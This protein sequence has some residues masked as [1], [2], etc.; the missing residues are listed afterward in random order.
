MLEKCLRDQW[1][2]DDLDWSLVPRPM[3]E[4]EETAIVQYFT[5]MA[6]IELLAG[7]LFEEQAKRAQDPVLRRILQTFVI[8]EAR[9]SQVAARLARHYDVHR[10][11]AY[12]MNPSLVAF[13]PH[14]V[15]AVRYL[16][17]EVATYYI[18]GGELILDVALLR[19]LNDFV[20]DAMSEAAMERINRDESRHIALDFHMTEMYALAAGRGEQLLPKRNLAQR[21]EAMRAFALVLY[22]SKPFFGEVFFGPMKMVDPSGTRLREA[23]KRVQLLQERD[24]VRSRPFIR[25]MKSMRDLYDHPASRLLFGRMV[26]RITGLDQSVMGTIY[27]EAERARVS[28][29]SFEQMAEEAVALKYEGASRDLSAARSRG[30]LM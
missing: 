10:F 22:Y 12:E 6:G 27:D 26:R 24:E 13:T 4:A 5:D 30:G 9:H 18:T 11:R 20:H 16:S 7:A 1:S 8:D 3:D 19:S 15:K 23:Y 29:L 2:I 25:F 17:P 21:I 28:K 14:F